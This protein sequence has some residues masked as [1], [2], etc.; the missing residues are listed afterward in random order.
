MQAENP[1]RVADL[2]TKLRL[3]ITLAAFLLLSSQ[4]SALALDY[5]PNRLIVKLNNPSAKLNDYRTSSLGV[6]KIIPLFEKPQNS[7]SGKHFSSPVYLFVFADE[8]SRKN[9]ENLLASDPAVEYVERDY[10]A[11]LFDDDP[12]F[13]DQWGLR[14]TGQDYFGIKR[15][16]GTEND[17]LVIKHGIA[18]ADIQRPPIPNTATEHHRT[19]IAIIDTGVDYFHPDLQDNIWINSGEIPSNGVDDDHNGY[20]DDYH[21]YDFSGDE[22]SNVDVGGDPNPIDTIGHGTHVAGIAAAVSGNGI[23]VEGVAESASVMCVKIFPNAYTSIMAKAIIYA[24]ENG[25]QVVNA[26]WGTPYFSSL[27]NEVVDFADSSGVLLV[28]ASGNSG[29][30]SRFYP[31]AITRII[32]VGAS[33]SDDQVTTFST[34]G[35]W[36]DLVAP[37][38]DILSLRAAGTDL[39]AE[40][41]EPNVRIIEDNYYLA[42]G[43][44]MAAPHVAGAAAYILSVTPGLTLDSLKNLILATTDDFVDPYGDGRSLP[45]KD[46]YSG[47]GR[48]NLGRAVSL[49]SGDY[50]EIEQPATNVYVSGMVEIIGSAVSVTGGDYLLEAKPASTGEWLT[51]ATGTADRMRTSLAEWDSSPY[52]GKTALRLSLAGQLAYKSTIRLVNNVH[53]ELLSPLDGDTVESAADII[54]SA[55][56]PDFDN[57][58]LSYYPDS[59]PTQRNPIASSTELVFRDLLAEWKV[60]PIRPGSG[61]IRLTVNAA[62]TSYTAEAPIIIRSTLSAG[63]PVNPGSRPSLNAALGNLDFDPYPDIVSGAASYLIVNHFYEQEIDSLKPGFGSSYLSSVALYDL[64]GDGVDEIVAVSDSGVVVVNYSGEMLPGWPKRI[65]TG[66]LYFELPTPLVVDID[67][68]S[69]MEILMVNQQGDIF[70]WHA[71]GSSCFGTTGGLFASLETGGLN[72]TFGGSGVPYLFAYDFNNDGYK[73]VGVVYILTGGQGGLFLLSGRNA[74]PLYPE[75]GALVRPL[76]NFFG[77]LMADFDNDGV[78]EIAMIHWY[79]QNQALMGVTVCEADGSI[80]PGWPRLFPDKSQ[81]FSTYPAAADLDGDS[82]PELIATF[83]AIDGGQVYVWHGD[84]RPLSETEFGPRDGFLAGVTSSLSG[85]IV[86]DVDADGAPEIVARGGALLFGAFEQVHAFEVDGSPVRGWPVYTYAN[87]STVTFSPFTPL[88]GDF[89]LDGKLELL[90]GSSDAR[91]YSWDLPTLDEKGAILWGKFLYDNEN[92]GIL[93]F[94]RATTQPQPPV[95]VPESY[96]LSQNF[97][98]PFNGSTT[99]EVELKESGVT[100]LEIFNILGQKVAVLNDRPLAAG[101]YR[102]RWD[103]HDRHGH[104]LASGLYFYRLRVNQITETRKMLYLK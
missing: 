71:D 60:G 30:N 19:L 1:G 59:S 15:N 99:V 70:C 44:S 36:V 38:L 42:D 90:M 49:A 14:N 103:A 7:L 72:R 35:S 97:P 40:G 2:L 23:G 86:V 84:G 102:F 26:S 65:T 81:W 88:A 51:I 27:L 8:S 87:P 54:G 5:S 77:G 62:G 37:G 46:I 41:G 69:T 18:G 68:D 85:P 93:P 29:D 50:V 91:I 80:L 31:A 45:G 57:W 47:A 11:Q 61:V 89:D 39:Y 96:S 48:L 13:H 100:R 28:A 17:S 52:D 20:V 55:S 25:A 32:T 76:E 58:D 95:T 33:N 67:G 9:A 22:V 24:V 21:G 3:F 43:T 78:P 10:L 73:D 79:G 6:S 83:S 94:K 101:K 92:S 16:P 64:D 56:L 75:K 63:Y 98:N 53:V 34:Y 12:L 74:Q 66:T 4:M 82:I 104:E